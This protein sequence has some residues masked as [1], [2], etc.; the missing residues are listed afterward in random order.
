MQESQKERYNGFREILTTTEMATEMNP[1]F[2]LKR[3]S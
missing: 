2:I 3:G 1:V